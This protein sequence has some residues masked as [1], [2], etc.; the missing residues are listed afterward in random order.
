[1]NPFD[2]RGPEFLAFYFILG[3]T[4]LAAIALRRWFFEPQSMVTRR[5]TDPSAIAYLRAGAKEVLRL[6]VMSLIEREHL[7]A[8]GS[9]LE[10]KAKGDPSGLSALDRLILEK[11]ERPAQASAV[12]ADPRLDREC[13]RVRGSLESMGLVPDRNQ[14]TLRL[15]STVAGVAV[16]IGVAFVKIVVALARGKT[17]VG[18]L[19]LLAIAFSA[20]A[21]GI[22]VMRRT[23]RGSAMLN[24][25][26]QLLGQARHR[27]SHAPSSQEFA[28][29]AAVYGDSIHSSRAKQAFPVASRAS[30]SGCGSAIG[31]SCG[32]SGGSSCGS[33]CGGGCGG[34]CG[35]CGS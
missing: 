1:V 30:S 14:L 5:L 18:F 4:V 13:S 8:N 17:N 27:L 11:F 22:A 12:F 34:G 31:S 26:R 15:W 19:V 6:A 10:T 24:D 23:P 9:Q 7:Q 35:G 20:A 21:V 29:V 2:W 32:S 33:S 25:M 3:I 28:L 16:L